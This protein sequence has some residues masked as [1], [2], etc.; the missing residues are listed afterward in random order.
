MKKQVVAIDGGSTYKTYREYMSHLKSFDIDLD[1][2]KKKKWRRSLQGKLGRNYEVLLL[3]MPNSKNA[4]YDEWEILFKRIGPL[5]RNNVIL[6][7]HSLGGVFLARYLSENKFPKKILATMLVAPPYKEEYLDEYLGSFA[8]SND[9]SKFKKQGGHIYIYQSK[10]DSI[11]PYA[12]FE[13]YMEVLPGT[14]CRVFKKRGHFNQAEFPEL[15]RD[16]RGL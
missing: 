13:K 11:V 3:K 15:V 9:L 8:V 14:V 6:I 10:D 1:R 4:K 12:N 5:L 2:Y 7:G 16:I